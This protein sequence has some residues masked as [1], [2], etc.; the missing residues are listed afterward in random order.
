MWKCQD[1]SSMI[2]PGDTREAGIGL[3]TKLN[4][5]MKIEAFMSL[6]LRWSFER[7]LCVGP[8]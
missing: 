6:Y 5:L 1:V 7:P 2:K 8:L 3:N 4:T